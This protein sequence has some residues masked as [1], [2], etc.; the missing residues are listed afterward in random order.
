MLMYQCHAVAFTNAEIDG[1]GGTRTRDIN[2]GKEADASFR[3]MKP[4]ITAPYGSDGHDCP[5][6]N[7]VVEVAYSETLNHAKEALKYWLSPGRA[8]D[9]IIVKIDPVSQ[10]QIPVRMRAWHYCIEDRRTINTIPHRTMFEFGTQDGTGAPLNISQGQCI[11]NIS[12]RCLYHDLM[13]PA[14]IPQTL[15]DPIQLDFY[16]AQRAIARAYMHNIH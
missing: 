14:Q 1:F 4:A 7:L 11:I 15:N 13:P 6:P 12:L 3:P 2:R 5:W 10:G 9:C 16:F 8:H